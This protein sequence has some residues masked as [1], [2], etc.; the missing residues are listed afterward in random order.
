[1]EGE[2]LAILEAFRVASF[3]RWSNIIFVSN[4][5]L[6]VDAIHAAHNGISELSYI[7]MSIKLLL[8]VNMAAHTL[9]RAVI[10]WSSRTLFDCIRHCIEPII[11]INKMS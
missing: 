8:Q 9:A 4:Y 10:S 3:G 11:I 2:V 7:I 6:V 1:L 5:K